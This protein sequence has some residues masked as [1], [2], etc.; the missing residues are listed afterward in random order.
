MEETPQFILYT[1][2]DS[3]NTD[4]NDGMRSIIDSDRT[5]PNGCKL[6]A[7]FFTMQRDT[8]CDLAYAFWED[9]SEIAIHTVHHPQLYAKDFPGSA[10][11]SACGVAVAGQ[12]QQALA[13]ARLPSH[14]CRPP[15]THPALA[16]QPRC[17]A[18]GLG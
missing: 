5:N 14:T 13:P 9:G 16:P 6:P 18:C 15:S 2:D 4:C 7:T 17:W 11:Q 10:M 3:I 1:H 12:R 8:D